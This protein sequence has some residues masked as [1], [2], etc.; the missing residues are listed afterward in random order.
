ML[1]Q[2]TLW[3]KGWLIPILRIT[4]LLVVKF[5][6]LW[7]EKGVCSVSELQTRP[8]HWIMKHRV[9]HSLNSRTKSAYHSVGSPSLIVRTCFGSGWA[10]WRVSGEQSALAHSVHLRVKAHFW[11]PLWRVRRMRRAQHGMLNHLLAAFAEFELKKVEIWVELLGQGVY[12]LHVFLSLD[13]FIECFASVHI[14]K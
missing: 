3:F 1:G 10:R 6:W 9:I 13:F 2:G 8:E 12:L 14:P 4:A 7:T 11:L 5:W